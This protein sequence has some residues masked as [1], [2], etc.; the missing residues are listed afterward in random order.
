MNPN[1]SPLSL[2]IRIARPSAL[3]GGILYYVVGVGIAK[4]LGAVI[5]WPQAL[6]GWVVI[7]FLLLTSQFLKAYYDV[8]EVK[9]GLGPERLPAAFLPRQGI[10]LVAASSMTAAA[11]MTVLLL[12]MGSINLSALLILF[13]SFL[14]A[15]FYGVPPVRLA[16][17]GY[18]EFSESVLMTSLIP[19]F[20]YLLQSGYM[21]KLVLMITLPLL[22]LYLAARLVFCLE[23]YV[24]DIKFG[25]QTLVVLLGWQRGMQI[26]NLLV[27]FAYIFIAISTF[28]GLPA[29]L[30]WPGLLTIPL[31]GFAVFQMTQMA[32]G[33]KPGWKV[34]N[35]TAAALPFLAAYLI[36]FALWTG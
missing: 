27:M 14:V 24:E 7:L 18:G 33:G 31:G 12:Q 20:A 23:D 6:V 5:L 22:A 34:L 15:F 13:C 19:T 21:H 3:V 8:G 4:Y 25:K 10:F 30:T 26:H 28:F 35:L 17:S 16:S 36:A 29:Q 9:P 2:F 1:L 11:V 32:A